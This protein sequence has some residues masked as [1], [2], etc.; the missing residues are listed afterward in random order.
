MWP[1]CRAHE[2]EPD[3]ISS[4]ADLALERAMERVGLE[5]GLARRL[6]DRATRS[7]NEAV[8]L[9]PEIL[10]D[11]FMASIDR[12]LKTRAEEVTTMVSGELDGVV[13]DL[14]AVDRR[15]MQSPVSRQQRLRELAATA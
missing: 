2:I 1:A 6:H 8:P 14:S 3:P 11:R 12:L 7:A 5:L 9:S 4:K 10:R 13:L 15:L